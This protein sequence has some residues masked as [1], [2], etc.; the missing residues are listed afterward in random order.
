MIGAV[1]ASAGVAGATPPTGTLT[2]SPNPPFVGVLDAE[3]KAKAGGIELK[4]K[5]DVAVL[6]FTLTYGPLA[7]SGWHEHPGIVLA[8]VRSGSVT[9]STGCGPGDAFSAGDSFTEVGPHLVAAGP[10]G[11]ELLITQIV[12]AA[13]VGARR[14]D[15]PAP[16]C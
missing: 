10:D 8:T 5:G 2:P 12:P 14:I 16:E 11:A 1:A 9:R 6:D 13:D 7:T 3:Q 4:T 15:L